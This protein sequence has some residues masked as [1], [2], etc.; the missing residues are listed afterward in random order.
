[1]GN[2]CTVNK[3]YGKSTGF[4][5]KRK[6]SEDSLS[7]Q[8][9]LF[10]A[11]PPDRNV[12]KYYE[13]IRVIG[14]GSMG[15]I[16]KVCRRSKDEHLNVFDKFFGVILPW[17]VPPQG[18]PHHTH[19]HP[20]GSDD[21][22]NEKN[23]PQMAYAVKAIQKDQINEMYHEEMRN[24]IEILKHLDHPNIVRIFESFE[25]KRQIYLVMEY[26]SGGDLYE[27]CNPYTEEETAK[28][29]TKILSAV[30]Y[31][32]RRGV[33]H[34]DLKFENIL[35]E[36]KRKNANIKIIDF[37]L[38]KV[39]KSDKYRKLPVMTDFVGTLYT[40][41]PE[42]RSLILGSRLYFKSSWHWHGNEPNCLISS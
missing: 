35:F 1:M 7:F 17:W 31:M 19:F 26:C 36:N 22:C 16:M 40:M 4:S 3:E 15:T 12:F 37:G 13:V 5:E 28:I 41:A 20:S 14:E 11:N 9:A 34:R 27:R 29:I 23:C 21:N 39:F 2:A 24:E 30:A 8:G 18:S 33:V 6:H 42:V 38:S 32:H 10:V 25:H